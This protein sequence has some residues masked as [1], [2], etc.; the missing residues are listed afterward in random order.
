MAVK[1]DLPNIAAN[2]EVPLLLD[3][4]AAFS[5]QVEQA[6]GYQWTER[7]AIRKQYYTPLAIGSESTIRPG[8]YLV[9]EQNFRD[10]GGGFFEWDRLYANI[11][12]SW[13]DTRQF[14]FNYTSVR[15]VI[16]TSGGETTIETFETS[17]SAQVSTKVNHTYQVGYPETEAQSLSD[18]AYAEGATIA[19]G[20]TVRP[21]E[22][23]VYLGDI[24][25]IKTYTLI[26][27]FTA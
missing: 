6:A 9:K 24:Y 4:S 20:T 11:P 8:Y 1:I 15:E 19:A 10:I 22:V 5:I 13:S 25:V 26:E 2:G 7:Y 21:K 16:T 18:P 23:E 12:E 3:G 27:A 17:R 14:A